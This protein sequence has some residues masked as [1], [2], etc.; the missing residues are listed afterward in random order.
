M[1]DLAFLIATL[2]DGTDI[3]INA[4]EIVAYYA[5]GDKGTVICTT[6]G[7]YRVREYPIAIDT[8]VNRHSE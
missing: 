2:K 1:R 7:E 8:F 4:K 3:R 6:H 5:D